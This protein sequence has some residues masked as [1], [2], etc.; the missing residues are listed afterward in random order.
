MT[1]ECCHL[2]NHPFWSEDRQ[3]FIPAGEFR[4]D[5]TLRTA[6]GTLTHVTAII[7]RPGA[8]PVYNLEVDVEHAYFV[9]A[10]GVLVH[11]QC[12]AA[13]HRH[14]PIPMF[15]GGFKKG[16]QMSRLPVS[17]HGEFHSLLS[18][19]LSKRDLLPRGSQSGSTMKWIEHMAEHPNAQREAFD[20][21]LEASRAID[22][23]H[24]TNI[25]QDFWQNIMNGQF[26]SF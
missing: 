24:G 9:S 10:A 12:M 1:T 15:L 13:S 18:E 6:D 26:K 23:K 4:K 17:V 14:H 25:T 2:A 20:A 7:P 16:Q 22:V 19:G 8:E 3:A 11:N 5:E 21:V